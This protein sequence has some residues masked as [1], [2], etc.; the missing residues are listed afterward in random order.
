MKIMKVV[1]KKVDDMIYYKYRINLPKK[2]VEEGSFTDKE[3]EVSLE[4]NKLIIQKT[5]GK[6]N[7]DKSWKRK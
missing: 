7:K 2:A 5:S 3:V 6:D 1:D 4:G